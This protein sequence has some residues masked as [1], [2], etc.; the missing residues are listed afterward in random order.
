MKNQEKIMEKN[1]VQRL[2]ILNNASIKHT[3]QF[4]AEIVKQIISS[5]KQIKYNIMTLK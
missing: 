2:R 1:V 5:L 3:C 4:I